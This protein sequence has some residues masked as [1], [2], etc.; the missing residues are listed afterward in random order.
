MTTAITQTVI[1]A[2]AIR[3]TVILAGVKSRIITVII[4]G[5]AAIIAGTAATTR[6]DGIIVIATCGNIES[7]CLSGK[8]SIP[9]VP[10]FS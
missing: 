10:D 6:S 8:W 3:A 2:G 5:M 1:Y 9:A 4:A 7:Q